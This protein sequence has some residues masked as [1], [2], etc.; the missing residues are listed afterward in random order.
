MRN[1]S[2]LGTSTRRGGIAGNQSILI[3]ITAGNTPCSRH[4]AIY[5]EFKARVRWLPFVRFW[6]DSLGSVA[7]VFGPILPVDCGVSEGC[8]GTSHF[9]PNS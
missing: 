5:S 7:R 9:A 2:H 4:I 8:A 1:L 3:R 6:S